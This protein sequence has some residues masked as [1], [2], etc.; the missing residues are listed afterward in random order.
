MPPERSLDID[1]PLD[2]EFARFLVDSGRVSL[3]WRA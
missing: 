3:H 1:M 2:L